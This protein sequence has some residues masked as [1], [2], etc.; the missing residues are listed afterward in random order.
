MST[1][2]GYTALSRKSQGEATSL[3]CVLLEADVDFYITQSLKRKV[4]L[5]YATGAAEGASAGQKGCPFSDLGRCL[6][7]LNG[8]LRQ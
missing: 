2:Y 1:E 6:Q 8:K 3:L 5:A 7:P 4:G